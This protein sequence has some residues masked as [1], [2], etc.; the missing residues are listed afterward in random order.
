[1]NDFFAQTNAHDVYSSYN[2]TGQR[3]VK[4]NRVKHIKT[5]AI[6][7]LLLFTEKTNASPVIKTLLSSWQFSQRMLVVLAGFKEN[8]YELSVNPQPTIARKPGSLTAE[9]YLFLCSPSPA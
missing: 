7:L 8:E 3:L 2:L 6:S 9:L 1:M 4:A 5:C